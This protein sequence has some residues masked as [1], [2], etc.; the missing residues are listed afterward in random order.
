[1]KEGDPK[2]VLKKTPQEIHKET[3]EV[4]FLIYQHRQ[5]CGCDLCRSHGPDAD[6]QYARGIVESGR[7]D[8]YKKAFAERKGKGTTT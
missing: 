5:D 2:D 7:G 4:A 1:M 8:D 6:Y 3:E